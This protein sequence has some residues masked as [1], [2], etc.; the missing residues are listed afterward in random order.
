MRNPESGAYLIL[1][2]PG[3]QTE[4]SG[5]SRRHTERAAGLGSGDDFGLGN[6][7]VHFR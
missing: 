4:V 7:R 5:E 1:R 6:H 3:P 2:K